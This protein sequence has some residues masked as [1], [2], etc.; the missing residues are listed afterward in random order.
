[1]NEFL[2]LCTSEH[3]DETEQHPLRRHLCTKDEDTVWLHRE[4][5]RAHC[6]AA[7]ASVNE[8]GVRFER[9]RLS[10]DGDMRS[11]KRLD[12]MRM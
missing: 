5:K 1:M 2:C 9:T 7:P 4:E 12:L 3:V 11:S 6:D 10:T 8:R